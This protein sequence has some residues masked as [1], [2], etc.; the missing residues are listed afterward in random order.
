MSEPIPVEKRF[1]V[2][3]EINR[4]S[5][6]AW[7]EAVQRLCPDV[8]PT[9]VVLEMWRITGEQTADAYLGRIDPAGDLANQF[10]ASI[11][12]SSQCMGEDALLAAGE[13]EWFVVHEACPWHRWHEKHGLLHEDRPGC[14][15]WFTATVDR[16]NQKLGTKLRFETLSALPDGDAACRRRIWVD[17]P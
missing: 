12:W 7:R 5:H 1:K 14:D 15:A 11:V 16:I 9:E 2:L 10:A 13:G 6:F 8:D 3:V 4:A 17:G